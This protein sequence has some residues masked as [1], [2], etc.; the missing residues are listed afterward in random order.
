[1][2]YKKG[3]NGQP[4]GEEMEGGPGHMTSTQCGGDLRD[5]LGSSVWLAAAQIRRAGS[6]T[7]CDTGGQ[8]RGKWGLTGGPLN[9]AGR[10]G[11]SKVTTDMRA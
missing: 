5:R 4:R 9:S 3:R 1:V 6:A 10:R 7:A 11:M 2:A 8:G